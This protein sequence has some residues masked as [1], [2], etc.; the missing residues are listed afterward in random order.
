MVREF[1]ESASSRTWTL[2]AHLCNGG[3]LQDSM[4]VLRRSYR[5]GAESGIGQLSRS[6]QA[7]DCDAAHP[8][9]PG[10]RLARCDLGGGLTP[11]SCRI[12]WN[13]GYWRRIRAACK[14]RRPRKPSPCLREAGSCV[15]CARVLLAWLSS[16]NVAEDTLARKGLVRSRGAWYRGRPVMIN[17]N[18]YQIRLFNGDIGIAWEESATSA[19][20]PGA[21]GCDVSFGERRDA[22]DSAFEAA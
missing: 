19:V 8:A 4:T 5:F 20:R 6:I 1:S 10:A 15:L 21:S 3:P 12:V 16:I 7:G 18:D 9:T 14:Q 2:P 22:K 11:A 13:V 17:R